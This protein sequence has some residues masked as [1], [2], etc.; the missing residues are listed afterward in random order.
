MTKAILLSALGAVALSFATAPAFAAQHT[1]DPMMNCDQFLALAPADQEA[2]AQSLVSAGRD[3]AMA[4]A[5]SN[6][7]TGSSSVTDTT[8]TEGTTPTDQV[9]LDVVKSDS[10]DADIS[11]DS[12]NS[13]DGIAA[14]DTT[15]SADAN[16]ST[17]G[18]T[19]VATST[20]GSTST[21]TDGSSDQQSDVTL[22]LIAVCTNSSTTSN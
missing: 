17:D 19:S 3:I 14:T 16:A 22:A 13:S 2:G 12:S 18:S 8:A 6:A 7:S 5:N 21:S 4:A 1:S 15:S 11:T 10:I 9:V 20:D